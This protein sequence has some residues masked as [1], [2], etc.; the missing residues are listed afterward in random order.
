MKSSL[1]VSICAVAVISAAFSAASAAPAPAAKYKAARLSIGQPDLQGTWSNVTI[2][3]LQR[4][5][6]YGNRTVM[7]PDEVR[8]AEGKA[9]DKA[10]YENR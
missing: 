5:P 10:T 1:L 2:T 6:Q 4:A 9:Q 3:P 8:A 7:T